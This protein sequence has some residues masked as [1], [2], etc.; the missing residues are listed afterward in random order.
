MTDHDAA[1]PPKAGTVGEDRPEPKR[2]TAARVAEARR[3]YETTDLKQ[4]EIARRLGFHASSVNR[5]AREKGW[6][7]PTEVDR[8][9]ALIR[10]VRAKVDA[11]IAKTEKVFEDL[12]PETDAER[13]A[14]TL[15]SLMRT[16]R[17]I[18][19]YDEERARATPRGDARGDADDQYDIDE[20]RDSLADRLDRL[21]RERDG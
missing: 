3:L 1:S 12:G 14:R 8:R 18:S 7:R 13:T 17:E 11:E 15:A 10:N 6:M 5:M 19:K 2:A 9:A 16:L 4:T 20:F 21:R